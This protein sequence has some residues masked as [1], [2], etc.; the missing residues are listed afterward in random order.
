[1]AHP[2]VTNVV[3][4][5]KPKPAFSPLGDELAWQSDVSLGQPLTEEPITVVHWQMHD[6]PEDRHP[7][8]ISLI[9]EKTSQY[10]IV[11]VFFEGKYSNIE[12]YV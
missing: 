12:Q 8:W 4:I 6:F 3:L 9:F 10:R 2:K 1:M 5:M 7:A 11:F